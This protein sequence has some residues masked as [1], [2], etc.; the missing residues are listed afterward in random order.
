M[1]IPKKFQLHGITYKVK[2]NNNIKDDL[3]LLGR[4]GYSE[5]VVE[6]VSPGKGI[7]K[8]IV[9]QT[10]CHELMHGIFTHAGKPKLSD[11]EEFVDICAS[12]LHQA[13]TTMRY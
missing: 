6:L 8:E 4:I 5:A 2:T 11:D 10:Y 7:S 1:K 13:L 3:N 9:E 12:L